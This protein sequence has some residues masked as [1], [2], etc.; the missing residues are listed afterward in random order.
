MEAEK[1]EAAFRE[2]YRNSHLGTSGKALS[3]QTVESFPSRHVVGRAKIAQDVSSRESTALTTWNGKISSG[4]ALQIEVQKIIDEMG[5]EIASPPKYP[6]RPHER[7]P[8][9]RSPQQ[10]CA[11]IV[12]PFSISS[13]TLSDSAHSSAVAP[14]RN[15]TCPQYDDFQDLLEISS[16]VAEDS[17]QFDVEKAQVLSNFIHNTIDMT[18]IDSSAHSRDLSVAGV[19]SAQQP[20]KGLIANSGAHQ[21]TS[22]QTLR[23]LDHYQNET[24]I[25]Q[26]QDD[27]ITMFTHL[28]RD[29]HS[30]QP[31]SDLSSPKTSKSQSPGTLMTFPGPQDQAR[32][33]VSKDSH[34]HQFIE[35]SVHFPWPQTPARSA[36]PRQFAEVSMHAPSHQALVD[37]A[38]DQHALTQQ[39]SQNSPSMH[40]FQYQ[41]GSQPTLSTQPVQNDQLAS[42][43]MNT[44]HLQ[45]QTGSQQI[46]ESNN[47]H[48]YQM[49]MDIRHPAQ[50]QIGTYQTEEAHNPHMPQIPSNMHSFQPQVESYQDQQAYNRQLPQLAIDASRSQHPIDHQE[51]HNRQMAQFSMKMPLFQPHLGFQETQEPHN[52]Q[53]ARISMNTSQ[54]QPQIGFP[55][56]F[57][58]SIREVDQMMMNTPPNRAQT[59]LPRSRDT[60]NRQLNQVPKSV[61]RARDRMEFPRTQEALNRQMALLATRDAHS[62]WQNGVQAGSRPGFWDQCRQNF[63]ISQHVQPQPPAQNMPSD[64][65]TSTA[66][67]PPLHLGPAGH[68][69]PQQLGGHQGWS[70]SYKEGA[71]VEP[72]LTPPFPPISD[73]PLQVVPQSHTQRAAYQS[74]H[75]QGQ[76]HQPQ[77]LPAPMPVGRTCSGTMQMPPPA[78]KPSGYLSKTQQVV[79]KATFDNL[80]ATQQPPVGTPRALGP[81]LITAAIER[82]TGKGRQTGNGLTLPSLPYNPGSDA[83]YPNATED[84]SEALRMLTANGRPSIDKLFDRDIVP[85]MKSDGESGAVDW[86]VIRIGNVSIPLHCFS[87]SH[88]PFH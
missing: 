54:F 36:I 83:M 34:T 66:L 39:L 78:S 28:P 33:A 74:I 59:N 40:L 8:S 18:S 25:N 1:L 15:I 72:L 68:F 43:M 57:E 51:S 13:N 80:Y 65:C 5:D 12:Q 6:T 21:M 70:S 49:L 3:P 42:T 52:G 64:F 30:L 75:N 35:D 58:A 87:P 47:Q 48:L 20:P 63:G 7:G 17:T 26:G 69:R 46:Q 76:L 84:P 60:H 73:M 38:L 14:Y 56:T 50:P 85:F 31:Q 81:K 61:R 45:P 19:T 32:F 10:T 22:L 27:G 41:V 11:S 88:Q 77:V 55:Q 67:F 44:H 62:D 23:Q 16:N 29:V 9:V 53:L 4:A 24:H 82:T 2:L 86:G 79:H 37:S 71:R